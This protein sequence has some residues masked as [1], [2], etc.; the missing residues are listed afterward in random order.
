M[1][2][3]TIFDTVTTNGTPGTRNDNLVENAGPTFSGLRHHPVA[4]RPDEVVTVTVAAADPDLVTQVQ[5]HYSVD[6]DPF[7][8]IEMTQNDEGFYSAEIPGQNRNDIVQFYVSAVD[9]L[10]AL[11]HFPA[12]GPD[13]RALYSVESRDIPNDRVQ[14]LRLVMTSADA[15]FLHTNSQVMSNGRLGATAIYND[16]E[17][18]YDVGVRLRA[19]GYGRRGSLAGFNIRFDPD[20]KFRDVH[21]SIAVDRGVVVS[22]GRGGGVSGRPGASP[23][24]LLIYQIAHHAGDLVGMY[25]DVVYIDAPRSGN[26]GLA[27]LKM[28][29]YSGV[30]LDSQFENG[31]DG[32]LYKFELFYHSTRTVN[33]RPESLKFPPEA[34]VGTDIQDLG[35]NEEAY[36]LQFIL[37]KQSR[38]RRL[39]SRD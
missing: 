34:V 7:Q 31:S 20:H 39:C 27:L 29:R 37:K 5:L 25:D 35:E 17:I 18:F 9:S 11:S 21:Q 32:S 15:T 38:P 24:E 19:S 30:Y 13:S 3:T 8:V 33:G 28:A 12:D 2:K 4:P 14:S 10:G 36:R 6:A 1:Q 16:S 22:N 23:H 26:T